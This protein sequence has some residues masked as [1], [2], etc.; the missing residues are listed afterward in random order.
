MAKRD[1]QPAQSTT[2]RTTRVLVARWGTPYKHVFRF[3]FTFRLPPAI[4]MCDPRCLENTPFPTPQP[5]SFSHSALWLRVFPR[6]QRAPLWRG[7]RSPS[8]RFAPGSPVAQMDPQLLPACPVRH[9]RHARFHG[10]L[11]ADQDGLLTELANLAH[12]GLCKRQ[13]AVAQRSQTDWSNLV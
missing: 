11:E 2:G 12:L 13:W 8:W 4:E 10:F 6:A 9:H 7:L 5:G 3:C 1:T